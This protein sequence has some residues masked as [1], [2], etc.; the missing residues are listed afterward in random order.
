M[1]LIKGLKGTVGQQV[2]RHVLRGMRADVNSQTAGGSQEVVGGCVWYRAAE[3]HGHLVT[4][5]MPQGPTRQ[6]AFP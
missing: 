2:W 4:E 5:N 3:G 6:A 1:C